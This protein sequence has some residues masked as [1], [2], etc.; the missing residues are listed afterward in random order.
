[1][2]A[3]YNPGLMRPSGNSLL[4]RAAAAEIIVLLAVV[5]A[6]IGAR[7]LIPL[8]AL[9]PTKVAGAFVV[10]VLLTLPAIGAHHPF[11]TFGAANQVTTVR[12]GLVALVV[13]LIGEPP[14]PAV[15]ILAVSGALFA[16]MLDG[17]DGWLARQR[18][19]ASAFGAR[20]D[21]ET[22]AALIL[23]LAILVWQ[24]GKAGPWVVL[25]GLLRYFFIAAGWCWAW[26]AA[27]L[28]SSLRGKVICVVQIAALILALVPAV[29]PPGSTAIAA[30]GLVALAYSFL[31]DT[32][33][34][35][36]QGH[37]TPGTGRRTS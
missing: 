37:Q 10:V 15:A 23:A 31:V 1:M 7:T 20:F 36:R 21:M 29:T 26:M 16:T 33:W 2:G 8:G 25:S 32:R 24:G 27:A 30:F 18:G 35:W 5:A 4:A 11:P 9:Y 13:S 28:P 17:A 34:L 3:G 6:A 22:D 14:T 19:M 12:A